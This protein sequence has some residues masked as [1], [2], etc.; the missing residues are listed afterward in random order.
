MAFTRFFHWTAALVLSSNFCTIFTLV[1]YGLQFNSRFSDSVL[2]VTPYFL[3][4]K[5]CSSLYPSI[6]FVTKLIF[7]LYICLLAFHHMSVVTSQCS[8]SPYSNHKH[9]TVLCYT[10]LT[11]L[12]F[13]LSYSQDSVVR[14]CSC[15]VKL[16]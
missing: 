8:L 7:I 13:F 1:S 16:R 14:H 3:P 6:I 2:L 5:N 15:D 4:V 12:L 11:N 9:T 10:R